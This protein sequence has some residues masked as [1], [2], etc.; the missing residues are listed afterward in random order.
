MTKSKGKKKSEENTCIIYKRL[1]L[2]CKELTQTLQRTKHMGFPDGS[3]GKESAYNVGNPGSGPGLERSPGK[4][5]GYPL[6]YSWG[7]LVA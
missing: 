5:I 6:Q 1:I 4:G 3:V 2:N 7:P